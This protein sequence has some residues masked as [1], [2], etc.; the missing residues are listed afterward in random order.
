M[1]AWTVWSIMGDLEGIQAPKPRTSMPRKTNNI[2]V[3]RCDDECA[4]DCLMERI[5]FYL[6]LKV[7]IIRC[8]SIPSIAFY[9]S[10][11]SARLKSIAKFITSILPSSMY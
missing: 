8:F 4:R 11:L 7:F 10:I 2:N 6:S 3:W 9:L 5:V 1:G